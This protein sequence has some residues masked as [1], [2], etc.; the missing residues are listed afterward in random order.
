MGKIP[1]TEKGFVSVGSPSEK[2]ESRAGDDAGK[3]L[4]ASEKDRAR[5][6]ASSSIKPSPCLTSPTQLHIPIHF[7]L[8]GGENK[9]QLPK[10]SN[11]NTG[12]YY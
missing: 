6:N 9:N 10:Q 8:R 7:F 12:D 1:E 4:I 5:K 11:H 3:Q 2:N